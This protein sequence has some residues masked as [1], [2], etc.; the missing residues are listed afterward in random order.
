M[1]TETERLR[2]PSMW[3]D[4]E[5]GMRRLGF[6]VGDLLAMK[7]VES[8]LETLRIIQQAHRPSD[9]D[10]RLCIEGCGGGWP[11]LAR[12]EVDAALGPDPQARPRQG[13]RA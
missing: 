5:R 12:A 4:H 6:L 2:Y 9:T 1:V 10:G 3:L 11:C 7:H 13:A 8:L